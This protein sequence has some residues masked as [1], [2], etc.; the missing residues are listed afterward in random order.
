MT[1][2][3]FEREYNIDLDTVNW[4]TIQSN[5]PGL[6]Y[7]SAIVGR[8][9]II[10]EDG[11]YKLSEGASYCRFIHDLS[12]EREIAEEKSR[13]CDMVINGR[14]KAIILNMVFTIMRNKSFNHDR[15]GERTIKEML[16]LYNRI[17]YDDYCQ[18]NGIAYSEMSDMDKINAILDDEERRKWDDV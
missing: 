15:L 6:T 1:K 11:D 2:E 4:K 17:R 7:K 18:E 13:R 14:D 10:N 8:F 3:R 9:A 5:V 16:E 12:K